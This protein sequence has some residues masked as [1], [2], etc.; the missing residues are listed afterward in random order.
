MYLMTKEGMFHVKRWVVLLSVLWVYHKGN[1]SRETQGHIKRA[2]LYLKGYGGA[3][4]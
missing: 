1:V 4:F 2:P 3:F